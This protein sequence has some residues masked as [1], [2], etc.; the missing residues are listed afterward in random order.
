M[1]EPLPMMHQFSA[2]DV[3]FLHQDGE[4]GPVF[5]RVGACQFHRLMVLDLGGKT[6]PS[7][8]GLQGLP[9]N[10]EGASRAPHIFFESAQRG[11]QE[12]EVGREP[13]I[14]R[15]RIVARRA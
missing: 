8:A 1:L 10:G 6:A 15:S 3:L 12:H 5:F 9:L 13:A 4:M 11:L 14:R 2:E 7:F